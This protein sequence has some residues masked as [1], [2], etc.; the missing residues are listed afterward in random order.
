[1]SERNEASEMLTKSFAPRELLPF[2]RLRSLN[3]KDLLRS[4]KENGKLGIVIKGQ[5]KVALIGIEQYE[6]MVEALQE[7]QRLLES[8]EPDFER[9]DPS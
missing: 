8:K 4:L 9:G 3:Q 2:N 7:Y 6:L 1:M 5:L